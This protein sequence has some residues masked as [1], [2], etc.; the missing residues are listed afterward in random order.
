MTARRAS[1]A[2]HARR[3]ALDEHAIAHWRERYE[4]AL[5]VLDAAWEV[6]RAY[7][8]YDLDGVLATTNAFHTAVAALGLHFGPGEHIRERAHHIGQALDPLREMRRRVV[9]D[10]WQEMTATPKWVAARAK[11]EDEISLYAESARHALGN[12]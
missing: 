1:A 4:A 2:E 8:R 3:A 9:S 12:D 6:I 11:V 7:D 5:A 10:Q